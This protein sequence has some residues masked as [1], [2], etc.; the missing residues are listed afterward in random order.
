MHRARSDPQLTDEHESASERGRFRFQ[1]CSDPQPPLRSGCDAHHKDGAL[2]R[3][4]L[5]DLLKK[6]GKK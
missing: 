2:P 6:R 4:A 3:E 5:G 1:R